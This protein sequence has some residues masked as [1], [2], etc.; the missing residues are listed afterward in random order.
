MRCLLPA[1]TKEKRTF[2][3]KMSSRPQ[4]S[5]GD[6]VIKVEAAGLTNGLVGLW[7]RKMFPLLPRTLGHEAAGVLAEIGAGESGVSVGDRVRIHPELSCRNCEYCLDDPEQFCVQFCFVGHATFGTEA[8][9][10]YER[11]LDGALAE[12]V[13]VPGP[14]WAV[15]LNP[16]ELTFEVAAKLHDVAEELSGLKSAQV[17]P[18]ATIVVTAATGVLGSSR[19]PRPEVRGGSANRGRAL[20]GST[21]PGPSAAAGAHRDHRA[22]GNRVSPSSSRRIDRSDHAGRPERPG[23][24]LR[25]L[26]LRSGH[27]AGGSIAETGWH[28]APDGAERRAPAH[29]DCYVRHQP[30][31]LGQN[32]GMQPRGYAPRYVVVG[33]RHTEDR[34]PDRIDSISARSARRPPSFANV[35]SLRGWSSYIRDATD[36]VPIPAVAAEVFK[37]ARNRNG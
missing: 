6:V 25:F 17:K 14:G 37:G 21:A 1:A 26:R 16:S 33:E 7:E 10:L 15:D 12:F 34:R 19:S 35:A 27:T 8:M 36:T 2:G 24:R 13:K 29:S 22:R 4:A 5:D 3:S 28:R 23:R 20:S 32:A 30:L 9:P 18:G 31:A 11:Y